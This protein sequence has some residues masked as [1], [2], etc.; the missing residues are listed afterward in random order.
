MTEIEKLQAQLDTVNSKCDLTHKFAL[1]LSDVQ[2]Q[3]CKNIKKL[4]SE[5]LKAVEILIEGK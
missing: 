4:T 5:I 1:E 2:D 3:L